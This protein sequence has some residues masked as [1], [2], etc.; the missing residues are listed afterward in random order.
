MCANEPHSFKNVH[1]CAATCYTQNM[2]ALG[3]VVSEKKIFFYVFPTVSLW[4]RSVAMETRVL[5][6]PG[7]KANTTFLPPQ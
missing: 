6:H 2:K 5:V 1:K 3:L 7:P 4:E